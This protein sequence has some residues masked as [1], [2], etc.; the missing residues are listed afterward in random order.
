MGSDEGR[1]CGIISFG[2]G[3]ASSLTGSRLKT[4][5]YDGCSVGAC[6]EYVHEKPADVHRLHVGFDSSH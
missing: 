1:L 6:A 5:W 4:F 2:G 3:S